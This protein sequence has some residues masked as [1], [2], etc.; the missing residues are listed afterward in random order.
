MPGMLLLFIGVSL[1]AMGVC[2]VLL[3]DFGLAVIN[4][5]ALHLVES[6]V[7]LSDLLKIFSLYD[8]FQELVF[9]LESLSLSLLVPPGDVLSRFDPSV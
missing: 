9:I 6:F 7:H 5:L 8:I 3:L 2:P 1:L 4:P